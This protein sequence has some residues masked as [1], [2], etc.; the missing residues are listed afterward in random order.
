MVAR[1]HLRTAVQAGVIGCLMASAA[2]A[3]SF[4][5]EGRLEESGV[6]PTGR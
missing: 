6:A 5:Y 4:V 3:G 1:A 2:T